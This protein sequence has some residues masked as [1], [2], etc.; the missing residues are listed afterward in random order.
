MRRSLLLLSLCS[1]LGSAGACTSDPPCAAPD[2]HP[3]DA[4][5]TDAAMPSAGPLTACLDR[6]GEL[7][8][9]PTGRLPCELIPPGLKLSTVR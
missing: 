6:P 2:E 3:A 9:P 4:G 8:R 1:L 7:P 5:L